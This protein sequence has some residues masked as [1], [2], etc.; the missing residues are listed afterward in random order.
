MQVR[1]RLILIGPNRR[2]ERTVIEQQIL[3]SD[4]EL[5]SLGPRMPG[6]VERLVV[7]LNALAVPMDGWPSRAR[8]GKDGVLG[9]LARLFTDTALLVQQSAGHRVNEQGYML[10]GAGQGVWAWF[11]YEHDEVG[12]Q[13]SILALRLLAESGPALRLLDDEPEF[14][15]DLFSVYQNFLDFAR[16]LVLPLD[17]E[18]IACA[19][20]DMDIPCVK[21]ERIPYA[22]VQGRFRIRPNGLLMLGHCRYQSV[23]DGTLCITRNDGLLPLL[24][25]R[26]ALRQRLKSVELPWPHRD[27]SEGNCVVT[28]RAIRAAERIGY[29]VVVKPGTRGNG[30]GITLNVANAEEIREAVERA[31]NASTQ[32]TVEAM[33]P[34]KTYRILVGNHQVLGVIEGDR[35]PPSIDMHESMLALAERVS[36]HLNSGLLAITI[37]TPDPSRPLGETGGAVVDVDLAPELDSLVST[38]SALLRRAATAFLRWMYPEGLNARIPI[39]AVTGTNG[40]TTTCRMIAR[41]MQMAGRNTG[42]VCSGGVYVG[43]EFQATMSDIGHGVDHRIFEY[44]NVDFAILEEFFG[45]IARQGFSFSWCDIAVCTN[46]TDDHLGRLGVHTLEQ[47][48]ALKA[49]LPARARDAV[50][51]NADDRYCMQMAHATTARKT[52]LVSCQQDKVQLQGRLQQTDCF[53]VLEKVDGADWIVIYNR[54]V[55]KP[56]IAVNDIPATFS[57]AAA[58]NTANA[59]HAAAACYLSG[60]S[61]EKISAALANFESDVETNPCR[62]NVVDRLPFRIIVDYAHNADGF[63]KLSA[64]IDKQQVKGRKI[65][66]LNVPGDRRDQDIIAAG[67]ELAG[68]FD[69][70]VCRNYV[71]LRGRKAEEVPRM[72]KA[73]LIDGGAPAEEITIVE[74]PIEAVQFSLEMA[75]P[76][77][78]LVLLLGENDFD[79][80]WALVNTF[81]PDYPDSTISS[82]PTK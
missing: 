13:S 28:R 6:L 2:S 65:V 77:D 78:L 68:H 15:G 80:S 48:A 74:E 75:R 31:R 72:L 71:D 56:L 39:V 37:V 3:F 58:H 34:G 57:G 16:P 10:D 33:V 62:L 69:H 1:E 54:E 30:K 50:V 46:V 9:S 73:G 82:A 22:G 25:D 41:I 5:E 38:D 59:M 42:M 44:P 36:V 11:E 76:G 20:H 4:A 45:R 32:V 81:Q 61:I 51:L 63:R 8:I 52:C 14:E 55:R 7:N 64:F 47:M 60:A 66:M 17:A 29:P 67:R 24:R 12:V 26:E 43:E 40:K 18:A 21:L 27:D 19:A 23:V 35:K 70:Y 79:D 49:A 53:V